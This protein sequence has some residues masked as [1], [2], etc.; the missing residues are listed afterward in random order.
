MA[1][2]AALAFVAI[3]AGTMGVMKASSPT[4]DNLHVKGTITVGASSSNYRI[5]M[6]KASAGYGYLAVKDPRGKDGVYL[7][8]SGR[9][10]FLRIGGTSNN[11]A[12]I[13]KDRS[14]DYYLSL[15]DYKNSCAGIYK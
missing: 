11:N 6:G 2:I 14:G 12:K 10:G 9:G 5:K 13:K 15:C 7:S 8:G 4:Y 1:G 3:V